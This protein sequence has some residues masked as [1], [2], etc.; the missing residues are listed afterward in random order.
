MNRADTNGSPGE[1]LAQVSAL[2]A[3][4][5][6]DLRVTSTPLLLLGAATTV[7]VLPLLLAKEGWSFLGIGD[8]VTS[9][10]ITVAFVILWLIQRRKAARSGVGRP[11]A[12]GAAAIVALC[13]TLSIAG[14][15][16]TFFAGP[17]FVFGVGLLTLGVMQRNRFLISW[18]ILIGGIGVLEKFFGISNRLRHP[19]W[20]PW[21]HPAIYLAL[22]IATVLAGL[23]ARWRESRAR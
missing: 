14:V 12:F 20:Q 11:A 1:S 5:R 10:L 19:L 9:L 15:A 22:A 17:F 6:R 3:E 2:R 13:L 21:V 18:A 16:F 7:G 23:I 4:V 8:W